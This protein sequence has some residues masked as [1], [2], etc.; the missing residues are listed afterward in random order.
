MR[1]F[2]EVEKA[3]IWIWFEEGMRKTF[4][5]RQ[6]VIKFY[7]VFIRGIHV[8]SKFEDMKAK[9]DLE[10]IQ[11]RLQNVVQNFHL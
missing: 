3:I 6:K 1:F 8:T 4:L 7:N 2:D 5:Q 10:A 11:E 9:K